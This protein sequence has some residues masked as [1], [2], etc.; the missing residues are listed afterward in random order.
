[1][2]VTLKDAPTEAAPTRIAIRTVLFATDFSAP[3]Q[4]AFLCALG[5]ARAYEA[6]LIILHVVPP[7]PFDPQ[8]GFLITP[9]QLEK[10]AKEGLKQLGWNAGKIHHRLLL[11]SGEVWPAVNDVIH[12][13]KIDLLVLGTHGRSGVGRLVLGSVAEEILRQ[14]MCPVLTVGPN[15]MAAKGATASHHAK[16]RR[17]LFAT[18]FSSASAAAMPLALSL[19]QEN[20]AKLVLLYVLEQT[21][22]DYKRDPERA[23]VFLTNELKK[24]VPEDAK[25]WCEP[26]YLIEFGPPAEKI[27]ETGGILN[28]DMIIMGVRSPGD[29]LFAATHLSASTVHKV[30][31]GAACPVL[32]VLG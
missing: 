26:E 22:H 5:I 19:A 23:L 28:A 31:I 24:M 7:A 18:D 2:N 10:N 11:R 4:E 25:L 17:I 30:V 9:D 16:A 29:R 32:T 21:D 1:M 15:A 3:A 27:L 14:A 20:Q 12:K 6:E 13:E 8:A